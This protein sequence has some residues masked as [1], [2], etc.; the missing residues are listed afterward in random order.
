MRIREFG[1]DPEVAVVAGIHGDEPCGPD[2]VEELLDD[3]PTFERPVKFVV[4]NERALEQG[5]RYVDEDLNRAFPGSPEAESHER[6]LA[7]R[8]RA[9][10]DGCTT[11]ALHSTQSY[12][13]PFALVDG[14]DPATANVCAHL[15]VDAVVETASYSE[16]R[17]ISYPGTVEV[18]CGRQWSET[19]AANA[20]EL[21]TAFLGAT[22]VLPDA[23]PERDDDVPVFR[24]TGKVSK[25]PATAHE[26]FVENFERVEPG[27]PFASADGTE[28]IAQEP[29][30]PI[31]MSAGGY[32]DVFG[33]AGDRVGRLAGFETAPPHTD[34]CNGVSASAD[35][36][37]QTTGTDVQ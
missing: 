15:P 17:L 16:G 34:Y 20:R 28:H 32:E 22:G 13:H 10:L 37:R 9:E 11:L 25:S 23:E 26:V 19:A 14:V 1:D 31:L 27:V 21:V 18:E 6:R 24:L 8:L 5:V 30:Y 12:A 29:F 4:A 35:P 7:H 33:Y 2:A 3:P 36:S